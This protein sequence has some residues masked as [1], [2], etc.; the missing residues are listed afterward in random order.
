MIISITI[1]AHSNASQLMIKMHVS[2]FCFKFQFSM[3]LSNV[4]KKIGQWINKTNKTKTINDG[5]GRG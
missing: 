4:K 1:F 3:T 2:N 5:R